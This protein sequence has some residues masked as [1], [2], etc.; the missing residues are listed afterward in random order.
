MRTGG[1]CRGDLA[2]G[3]RRRERPGEAGD[4]GGRAGEGERPLRGAKPDNPQG[5]TGA[6]RGLAPPAALSRSRGPDGGAAGG[7][8][9]R[10]VKPA[11]N[12]R[13]GLS[14]ERRMR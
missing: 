6:V 2:R 7:G 10:A 9:S 4:R 3:P 11:G 8:S 14:Q 12:G 1:G 13:N 5:L